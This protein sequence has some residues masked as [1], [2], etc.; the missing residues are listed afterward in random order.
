MRYFPITIDFETTDKDPLIAHPIEC[1]LS[2][3]SGPLDSFYIKPPI[4]IPPETSAVH[5]IIDDDVEF[6]SDWQH[7]QRRIN[8]C[9]E[10]ALR[11]AC[12]DTAILIAHNA[13]Y[14]Q[15]ILRNTEIKSPHAWV[16]TYKCSMVL[17]PDAPSHSNEG[18]RYWLKLGERGRRAKQQTHS[19]LHDTLVTM[20]LYQRMLKEMP[21]EDMI[22]CTKAPVQYSKM[23]FG[24]H[25]GETW[26]KVPSSYLD[27]ML[28]QQDMEDDIKAAARKALS[29]RRK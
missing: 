21:I 25:R 4:S 19:A 26:D 23:P 29:M 9:I 22:T 14:E 15:T 12:M 5:H 16:C 24:K 7:E 18:L 13:K 27:W 6:A 20:Q 11:L 2:G 8:D 1:A 28:K 17:Y 10:T 3:V